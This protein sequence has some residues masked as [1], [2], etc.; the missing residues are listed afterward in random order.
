LCA[1]R[2][3]SESTTAESVNRLEIML[4]SVARRC[5]ITSMVSRRLRP[6]R[7]EDKFSTSLLASV[8]PGDTVWDVGANVGHYTTQLAEA[9]RPA[10][11]VIAFEP[12]SQCAVAVSERA[13][14]AGHANV[15]V[16]NAALG[17]FN[18]E[19]TMLLG[20]TDLARTHRVE[21][22]ANGATGR[23]VPVQ[24]FTGDSVR[25]THTLK[26]PN[27]IKLDVEGFELEC[28]GG[29]TEILQSTELR[30]VFIEV[31]FRILES[32][33]NRFAPLEIE[34]MLRSSGF[35]TVEWVDASHIA[36]HQQR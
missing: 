10:G 32:R 31:H 28:L 25:H 9:V 8:R 19:A 12:V 29:M 27:V 20:D 34:T 6:A 21:P 26:T 4:R 23:T 22:A 36:A 11:E 7:N 35:K 17:S 1:S 2:A 30:S 33:G 3:I 14:T 13:A 18:G 24:I 16:I 5:G 15:R